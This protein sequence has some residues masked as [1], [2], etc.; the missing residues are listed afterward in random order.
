MKA[1]QGDSGHSQVK[2]VTDVYSHI[3]DDDRKN[4]AQLFQEA[5]YEEK[6]PSAERASLDLPDGITADTLKK[7]I[8]DP[9]IAALLGALAKKL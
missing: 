8:E 9:T 4:N 2:M 5:F 3:I 1:V 6:K 7:M